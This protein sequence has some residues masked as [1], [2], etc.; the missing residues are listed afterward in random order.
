LDIKTSLFWGFIPLKFASEQTNGVPE[1]ILIWKGWLNS[2]SPLPSLLSLQV[3]NAI[4][5]P[6]LKKTIT[7]VSYEFL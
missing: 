6:S 3:S 5:G 1:A 7:D 2:K 4:R